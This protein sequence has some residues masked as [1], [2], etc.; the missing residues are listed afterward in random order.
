MGDGEVEHGRLTRLGKQ[1]CERGE[2]DLRERR[3]RCPD[4]VDGVGE[5][6]G[7]QLPFTGTR[8][9]GP[10]EDPLHRRAERRSE[11]LVEHRPV[12]VD[13]E[14]DDRARAEAGERA[15]I[16]GARGGELRDRLVRHREDHRVGFGR[17]LVEDELERLADPGHARLGQHLAPASSSVRRGRLLVE[18]AEA[19][20]G[21]ADVRARRGVEHAGAEDLHRGG[22]GGLARGEVERRERDQVPE[23]PDRVLRLPMADEPLAERL[24]VEQ[25]VVGVEPLQRTRRG[26]WRRAAPGRRRGL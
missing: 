8:R 5:R 17:P 20:G 11:R 21:D 18:F 13:V 23:R 12:V 2:V 10:V 1:P 6:D 25:R 14:V 19:D 26:G 3:H 15:G 7:D 4:L 9:G 22:E 16:D 24:L